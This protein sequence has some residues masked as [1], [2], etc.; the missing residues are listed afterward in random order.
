[1]ALVNNVL[2]IDDDLVFN[3]ISTK[4]LQI[5]KFGN[6]ITCDLDATQALS[7]LKQIV[8]M[9]PNEFPDIIFLD[10]NMPKM[11]GWEFLDEYK[12]F[13]LFICQKCKVF[14]LSS[15]IDDSDIEKSKTYKSVHGFISKPL[16][17]S[18]LE[19]LYSQ[20]EAL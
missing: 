5:A 3:L 10:I 16:T 20:P 17:L 9:N 15:S 6:S 18:K 8:R 13:P 19:E 14:I 12:K 2:L 1:M 7:K 4:T 11:D